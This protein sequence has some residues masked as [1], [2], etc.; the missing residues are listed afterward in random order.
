MPF[1][2]PLAAL[3]LLVAAGCSSPEQELSRYQAS[4]QLVSEH[5]ATFD[6]LDF[7]VFTHQKWELLHVS[8]SSDVIVHWPD[9]HQTQGIDTHIEDPT[10]KPFRLV[11]NTVGRWEGGVMK[12][13]YLFW[14]N[15]TYAKQIGLSP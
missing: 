7:D 13:E 14:D 8:H 10:G 9:G 11:M 6:Q 1:R 2:T 3:A 5:L 4:E 15:Q 12:E